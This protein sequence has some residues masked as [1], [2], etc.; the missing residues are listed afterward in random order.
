M[1]PFVRYA[2]NTKE[3]FNYAEGRR[4]EMGEAPLHK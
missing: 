4:D 3:V 1:S 2:K